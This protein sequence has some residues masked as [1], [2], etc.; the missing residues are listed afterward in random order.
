MARARKLHRRVRRKAP[1]VRRGGSDLIVGGAKDPAEGAADR[2]AARALTGG[3]KSSGAAPASPVVR[4]NAQATS[5][6]PGSASAP[7]P[8]HAANLVTLLGAGRGH[9]SG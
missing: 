8:K 3:A 4:R 2:L 9:F 1:P 7:A 6:A 5:L